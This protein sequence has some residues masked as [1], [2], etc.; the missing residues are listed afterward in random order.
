MTRAA[1]PRKTEK[2]WCRHPPELNYS[3]ADYAIWCLECGAIKFTHAG[4]D[5][6]TGKSVTIGRWRYPKAARKRRG[7]EH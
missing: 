7:N 5:L 1:K 2:E 6:S 3:I 4:T